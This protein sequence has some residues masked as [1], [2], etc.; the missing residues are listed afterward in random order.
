MTIH[1]AQSSMGSATSHR[2]SS[3]HQPYSYDTEECTNIDLE[4]LDS[5]GN[6]FSISSR[7]FISSPTLAQFRSNNDRR[8]KSVILPLYFK[9]ADTCTLTCPSVSAIR[10]HRPGHSRIDAAVV[11][12]PITHCSLRQQKIH[13]PCLCS[14][15]LVLSIIAL[16]SERSTHR[17][18][19][20]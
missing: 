15:M 9:F 2:S 5:I 4:I 10:S 19:L 1:N 17:S 20:S 12:G 3:E 18:C 7:S 8:C 16:D 14:T 11:R 13:F 6:G